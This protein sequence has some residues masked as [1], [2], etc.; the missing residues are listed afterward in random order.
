MSKQ[1]RGLRNNNPGNIRNSQRTDWQGEVDEASK[2]DKSF[3]EFETIAYGYRALIK[4]LQNY[5]KLHG[6]QTMADFIKRWAPE[7]ENNTSAYIKRV[8]TEMQV[9]TTYV[10]DV[11]DKTTMCAFAAAISQVENGVSAVMADVESGWDLL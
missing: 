3:E 7:T 6:C 11:N 2:N 9:P 10:P 5:R 8:C 1:P 4:L